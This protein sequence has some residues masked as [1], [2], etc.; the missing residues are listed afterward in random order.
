LRKVLSTL[1]QALRL[2]LPERR[3]MKKRNNVRPQRRT[4]GRIIPDPELLQQLPTMK[5]E[6]PI[7]LFQPLSQEQRSSPK[8][9]K[10]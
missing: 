4:V 1:K 2:L 10:L 6:V 8:L 7:H 9:R 3:M 5:R